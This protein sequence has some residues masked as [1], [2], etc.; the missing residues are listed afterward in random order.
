MSEVL[1]F[2]FSSIV[3][4]GL[5]LCIP[6][7]TSDPFGAYEQYVERYWTDSCLLRIFYGLSYILGFIFI[8]SAIG[9]LTITAHWWYILAYI[10]SFIGAYL[11]AFI[12]RP[13]IELIFNETSSCDNLKVCRIVGSLII[14]ITSIAYIIIIS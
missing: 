6:E 10:G 14:C 13:V 11:C 1:I 7:N 5:L 9:Y 2:W 4:L 8:V 3:L 12:L